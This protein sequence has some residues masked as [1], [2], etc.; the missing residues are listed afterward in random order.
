MP[1]RRIL[2]LCDPL[3]RAVSAPVATP[4]EAAGAFQDLRDTL[5]EFQRAHGFGRGIGAVQIGLP[6]RLIYIELEGRAW[7]LRNPE[8]ELRSEEKL[9]LR[10]DC[11]SFPNLLVYVERSRS[12]RIRFKNERGPVAQGHSNKRH[13]ET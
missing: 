6:K 7:H 1:V 10:D 2:Q 12:V 3:L 13:C 5:H 8:Y 4:G 9:S 11:F